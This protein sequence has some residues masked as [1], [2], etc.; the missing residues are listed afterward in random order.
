MRKKIL[1]AISKF[2]LDL[3]G[4]RVLTEAATGNYVVT[5]VI[6]AVAG[7]EVVGFTRDSSYGSVEDVKDQTTELAD[8]LNVNEKIE[9]IDSLDG[10]NLSVFD[11][12]TNCGFLRPLNR[13]FV[14]RL[15]S[16]CVIPLMYEPWEYR[17]SDIDLESCV[18]KGV[19][20][21]GTDESDERLR[22]M[23]YIGYIALYFL[24]KKKRSPFSAK[25]LVL[26]SQ[27]FV[28]PIGEVLQQ[29]GYEFDLVFE[30][31][32]VIDPTG[33]DTIV[34]AEM[35]DPQL[36]IG[37]TPQSIVQVSDIHPETFVLHI[38]GN[39]DFEGALFKYVPKA[40]RS[41]GYMSFTTDYIDSQAVIDLHAAG[42]KVAQ[43]MLEANALGLS[44]SACREYMEKNYPALAFA[45][46]K[47]W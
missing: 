18:A 27:K 8:S 43:G 10:L 26:G 25:V 36:I 6:A 7:A 29:N 19:K 28:F 21:Y 32:N 20:V 24:L 9:V 35:A 37:K 4:C 12:V 39:V 46:R 17:D 1:N 16:N 41:L 45:D 3:V 15:S 23:T 11:I 13:A 47:M 40:P 42:L 34:V 14:S 2:D 5:A 33:Y 44:G 31:G 30:Y 38:A 22:T